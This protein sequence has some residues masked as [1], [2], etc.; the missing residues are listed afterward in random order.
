MNLEL[1]FSFIPFL[2]LDVDVA[3]VRCGLDIVCTLLVL[4]QHRDPEVLD[5]ILQI[6][7]LDVFTMVMMV[8]VIMGVAARITEDAWKHGAI[9]Y[10]DSDSFSRTQGGQEANT[11]K[12]LFAVISTPESWAKSWASFRQKAAC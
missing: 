5:E 12:C 2:H 11:K 9:R 7:P 10:V 8:T 3:V 1:G 4:A 6:L